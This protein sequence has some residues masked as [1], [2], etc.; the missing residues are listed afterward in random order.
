M[1]LAKCSVHFSLISIHFP[2]RLWRIWLASKEGHQIRKRKL[3]IK[4]A[5]INYISN[6]FWFESAQWLP[7]T[8]GCGIS[9][10]LSSFAA[11]LRF[12]F[13]FCLISAAFISPCSLPSDSMTGKMANTG[14]EWQIDLRS[15]QTGSVTEK[16]KRTKNKTDRFL[17]RK[18]N[19]IALV[20]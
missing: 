20:D 6:K 19:C 10:F 16:R 2:C 3:F 18:I 13:F 11:Q 7:S 17:I 9:I 1:S 14:D 8:S 12:D 5:I 15:P 4:S